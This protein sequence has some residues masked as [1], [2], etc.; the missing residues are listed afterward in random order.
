MPSF[1]IVN[2]LAVQLEATVC[3]C[4]HKPVRVTPAGSLLSGEIVC[5]VFHAAEF[6]SFTKAGAA[7]GVTVG[8]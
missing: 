4:K 3:D 1:A 6:V 7:G 2:E 8:V 5:A